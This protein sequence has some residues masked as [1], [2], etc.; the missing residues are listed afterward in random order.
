VS[1]ST[2]ITSVLIDRFIDIIILLLCSLFLYFY[3]P[4]NEHIRQWLTYLLFS[5][6]IL[7]VLLI[8]YIK[9]MDKIHI[10]ITF[11]TRRFLSKWHLKLNTFLNEIKFEFK[12]FQSGG[13]SLKIIMVAIM[14]LISDYTAVAASLSAFN[15]ELP[16]ISAL[17]LWVFL[18][19]GSAL[20][21]APGYAGV[22]QLAAILALSFFSVD[23]SVAVAVAL[24]IQILIV[25]VVSLM[26]LFGAIA[27]LK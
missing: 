3:L 21:S 8:V 17:L 24:L 9:L 7:A 16:Y 10:V 20:P 12:S 2:A 19:L 5:G 14:V 26:I 6:L 1:L 23:A 13:A 11:F 15:L 25:I 4:V 22:Y 27:D 18:A